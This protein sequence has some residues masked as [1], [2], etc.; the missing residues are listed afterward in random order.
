MGPTA[1]GKTDLAVDL[2]RRFPLDIVSVDS[3]MVYRGMDV[4]TAKPD[5]DILRAVPHRL[6]DILE[7]TEAYSAAQFRQ[8]AL[9]EIA[10]IHAA[11]RVPLLVGGTFLYFRALTH[12][13][14]ALPPADPRVREDLNRIAQEHGWRSLHDRLRA[15]DP[16]AG[17]RIHPN[18][19][20]RIQRA[21]EVH[22]LTGR[23]MSSFMAARQPDNGRYRYIRLALVPSD[24]DR[25]HARIEARFHQMLD[26]GFVDEVRRLRERG[27]LDLNYPSM[28]AV[29][30]RQIWKYLDGQT[31]YGRMVQ[32]AV[33]AS[34]RYAKR[35]LTWLRTERELTCFPAEERNLPDRLVSRVRAL[36][37]GG[38]NAF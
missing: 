1:S 16:E 32:S 23:P 17:Q 38:R 14:S 9:R 33:V 27:D 28:R 25:L 6:I 26:N 36:L 31:D 19:T 7:P 13:L 29:G 30:Y 12:G 2:A 11:G 20:Q 10:R 4:G 18:D 35:Q 3:A 37:E 8:D 21:L 22:A 24:R 5:P 15:V 34:R